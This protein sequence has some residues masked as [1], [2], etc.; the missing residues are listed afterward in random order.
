VLVTFVVG[1]GAALWLRSSRR[2]VFDSIGRTVLEESRE[3]A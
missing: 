3:R 2:E 1:L